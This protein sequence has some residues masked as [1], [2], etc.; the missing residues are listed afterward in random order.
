MAKV[1][2]AVGVD[3]LPPAPRSLSTIRGARN[4]LCRLYRELRR[5]DVDPQVVGRAA[6][7]VDPD[8][9]VDRYDF[10][11]ERS[12]SPR[13]EARLEAAKPNGSDVGRGAPECAPALERRLEQIEAQLTVLAPKPT[14]L[15]EALAW[16]ASLNC[17]DLRWLEELYRRLAEGGGEP[18]TLERARCLAIEAD[19]IMRMLAG[20][21]DDSTRLKLE[22]EADILDQRRRGKA[23]WLGFDPRTDPLCE[24]RR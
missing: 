3:R 9:Q 4:E 17:E 23:L 13:L 8:V 15:D 7:M 22:R 19:A 1:L 21:P 6:N 10:A 20:E 16:V 11:L 24:V 18:T 2:A 14:E 12:K 5:G